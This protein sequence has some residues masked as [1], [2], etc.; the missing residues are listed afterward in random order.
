M[1]WQVDG[2][3]LLLSG[4]GGEFEIVRLPDPYYIEGAYFDGFVFLATSYP[5]YTDIYDY[6]DISYGPFCFSPDG[7]RL[8][9]AGAFVDSLTL[10]T[11]EIPWDITTASLPVVHTNFPAGFPYGITGIQVKPDGLMIYLSSDYDE[12][13]FELYLATPW[14]ITSVINISMGEV[15]GISEEVYGFG[16]STDG[17][18]LGVITADASVSGIALVTYTLDTPW[19]LPSARKIGG[20][21]AAS[22]PLVLLAYSTTNASISSDG[23]WLF[24]QSPNL[25]DAFTIFHL[26][27]PWDVTTA[28]YQTTRYPDMTADEYYVPVFVNGGMRVFKMTSHY[29]EQFDIEVS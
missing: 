11:L 7:I 9:I 5:E 17:R 13:I 10:F 19:S 16:S 24:V 23:T 4:K 1:S 14:D 22:G 28:V 20:P 3:D 25:S 12:G 26:P 6:T 15:P 18:T 21:V 27:V 8:I 2:R 29:I